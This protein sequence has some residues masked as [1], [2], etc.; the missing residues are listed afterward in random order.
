MS[1]KLIYMPW[2]AKFKKIPDV[3]DDIIS[4]LKD[5]NK[6]KYGYPCPEN[7]L[8]TIPIKQKYWLQ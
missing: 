5:L 1:A 3:N 2:I 4:N 6:I 8:N 7:K